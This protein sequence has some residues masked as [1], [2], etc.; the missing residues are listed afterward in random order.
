MSDNT[1]SPEPGQK[2][3][4][5]WV[6]GRWIPCCEDG[7]TDCPCACHDQHADGSTADEAGQ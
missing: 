2:A 1:T 4:R 6:D 7:E 5:H 3:G